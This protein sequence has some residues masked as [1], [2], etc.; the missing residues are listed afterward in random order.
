MTFDQS[1]LAV[2]EEIQKI[3]SS[4]SR[5][6]SMAGE[7]LGNIQVGFSASGANSLAP[8]RAGTR[9]TGRPDTSMS[10]VNA[11]NEVVKQTFQGVLDGANIP[12]ITE[13]GTVPNL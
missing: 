9:M 12:M 1:E 10:G 6:P 4:T 7:S 11:A 2:S 5:N 8:S 3:S 13:L